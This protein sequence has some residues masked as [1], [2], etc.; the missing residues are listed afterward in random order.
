MDSLP[1]PL[2]YL[3][4]YLFP[5]PTIKRDLTKYVSKSPAFEIEGNFKARLAFVNIYLCPLYLA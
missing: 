3:I 5:I 2:S 4:K 1:A